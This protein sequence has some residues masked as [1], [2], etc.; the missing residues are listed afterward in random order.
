MYQISVILKRYPQLLGVQAKPH[1]LIS[2]CLFPFLTLLLCL[3][4]HFLQILLCLILI[5]KQLARLTFPV[6]LYQCPCRPKRSS[7]YVRCLSV[8]FLQ[9]RE[10]LLQNL[11]PLI[12]HLPLPKLPFSEKLAIYAKVVTRERAVNSIDFIAFAKFSELTT[13]TD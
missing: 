10:N 8:S 12:R 3:K 1:H 5:S 9:R 6:F 2:L 13:I 11:R 4:R 7:G